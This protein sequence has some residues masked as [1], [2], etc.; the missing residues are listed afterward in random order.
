MCRHRR[1]MPCGPCQK[2]WEAAIK[3]VGFRTLPIA[4]SEARRATDNRI[5]PEAVGE[6]RN[7]TDKPVEGR[8]G[9]VPEQGPSG[10]VPKQRKDV[11]REEQV[12]ELLK[13]LQDTR[14]VLEDTQTALAQ[15]Q[16]RLS[17]AMDKVSEDHRLRM[18]RKERRKEQR[19]IKRIQAVETEL[20]CAR[21]RLQEMRRRNVS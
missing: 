8:S 4:E 14:T 3:R 18:Q 16:I 9:P 12:K 15:A 10:S 19:R 17:A 13:V 6:N 11:P 2:N 1:N 21:T 5:P 20:E 7:A